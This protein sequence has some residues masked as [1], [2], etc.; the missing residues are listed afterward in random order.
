M[1]NYIFLR[2]ALFLLVITFLG[3]ATA[4]PI[5]G[6][7]GTENQLISCPSVDLCYKK[8]REVCGGSYKIVNTSTETSGSNG[9]VGTEINLLVKCAR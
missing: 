1:N 6:P 7:D 3:C 9:N 4:R 5:V 8:A 2:S